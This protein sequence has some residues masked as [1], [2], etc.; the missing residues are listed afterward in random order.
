[1]IHGSCLCGD[2]AWEAEGPM[3]PVSHCHCSRCRKAHGA[4]FATYGAVPE[5]G[6][7]VARGRQGIRRFES[8]PG[9][10]RA[11]CGT[12]GSKVP[13]DAREGRVFVPL[14]SL[15]DDPGARPLAHIFVASKA[16]WL[17]ISDP[18]PR[19]DAW[20]PGVDLPTVPDTPLDPPAVGTIRGSCLCGGVAYEIRGPVDLFRNCHCSR[21]RKARS[22]AYASN[23]F[24]QAERFRMTRGDSLL[25]SFK[26]PEAERFTHTF[27]GRCGASVPRRVPG[28]EY[29]V[30][31]AGSLDDDPGTRPNAHIFVGSKAPWVELTDPLPQH[32]AY[33][34]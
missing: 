9:F 12:C 27:C 19:F 15:D 22:A 11:F 5:P 6:F 31:P 26:V 8:S 1:M 30:I 14:G 28:R 18:L 2:V 33:P 23:A 7:R 20:P 10:F 3:Q 16:P 17:E 4:A 21:C 25:E 32:E 34:S 24:V 29:V 13:T